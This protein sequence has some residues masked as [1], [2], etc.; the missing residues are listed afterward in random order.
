[1]KSIK[2]VNKPNPNNPTL[3]T[4][5]YMM[6]A[7]LDKRDNEIQDVFNEA[8]KIGSKYIVPM[9]R[10][11]KGKLVTHT[12]DLE[13]MYSL[14][15]RLE[16][17]TIS[18][19][20]LIVLFKEL[21]DSL[22]RV[23]HIPV[24]YVDFDIDRVFITSEG[25]IAIMLWGV[26]GKVEN[27]NIISLFQSI[28]DK[29]EPTDFTDSVTFKTLKDRIP[30]NRD[31]YKTFVNTIYGSY[32]KL[33]DKISTSETSE[34]SI[35]PVK[36]EKEKEVE[37]P[38]PRKKGMATP[39]SVSVP[40]EKANPLFTSSL[41]QVNVAQDED[42]TTLNTSLETA[43]ISQ[44]EDKTAML[45]N[46][47]NVE[48]EFYKL[49]REQTGETFELNEGENTLGRSPSADI[50]IKNNK[51][52]SGK[53]MSI[54]VED[55]RLYLKDLN[56]SNGTFIEN[57]KIQGGVRVTIGEKDNFTISDEIFYIKKGS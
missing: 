29:A 41:P 26:D 9:A 38:K 40:V 1:M 43:E 56:S 28:L 20:E 52:I 7:T 22:N 23:T 5:N 39:K 17:A 2:W 12:W 53:H 16:Q 45:D 50:T 54:I 15:V 51:T 3:K 6:V 42:K 57:Q 25:T 30:N 4:N 55:E 31:E 49:V 37:K 21:I 8:N 47:F 33:I 10:E 32:K 48:E 14:R 19:A 46:D 18:D 35:E 27:G 11:K 36:E 13:G 44:E 24:Q 34:S